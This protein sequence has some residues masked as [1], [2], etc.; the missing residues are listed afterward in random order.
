MHPAALTTASST[1]YFREYGI[2][3]WRLGYAVIPVIGKRPAIGDWTRFQRRPADEGLITKWAKL[4]GGTMSVG[5]V[6]GSNICAADIDET[7]PVRAGYMQGI[8][9]ECCGVAPAVRHNY[10]TKRLIPYGV[11]S[12]PVP[13]FTRSKFDLIGAGRQFVAFGIHPITGRPYVWEGGSVAE[14]AP[15]D[16]PIMHPRAL[17]DLKTAMS[18]FAGPKTA[19]AVIGIDSPASASRRSLQ[20]QGGTL[21]KVGL[22]ADGRELLLTKLVWKRFQ[23]G[24]RELLPLAYAAWGEFE[25]LVD[26]AR[27]K[28]SSSQPWTIADAFTKAEY[29]LRKNVDSPVPRAAAVEPWTADKRVAF[30]AQVNAIAASGRLPPAAVRVSARMLEF[31]RG[32]DGACFASAERLARDLQ[33]D[34]GTVKRA[35]RRLLEL[36]LWKRDDPGGGRHRIAR[37]RPNLALL[38]DD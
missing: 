35:R 16:L 2:P 19:V 37:Y 3:A 9:F 32:A 15:E 25:Q 1:A 33:L 6:C 18:A 28:G 20:T 13:S 4:Q 24:Y 11:G 36:G 23:E 21:T 12:E 5:I 10:G 31:V 30:Q 7:D 27:G 29:L 22:I 38:P 14:I 34:L 26:L 17:Q 8:L